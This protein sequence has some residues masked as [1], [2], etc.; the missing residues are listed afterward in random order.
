MLLL[1]ILEITGLN[2]VPD[3]GY[4]VFVSVVFFQALRSN[5]DWH[6]KFGDDRFLP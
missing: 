3:T 5:F 4:T 2:L 6:L 1:G